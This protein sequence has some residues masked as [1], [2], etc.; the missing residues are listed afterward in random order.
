VKTHLITEENGSDINAILSNTHPAVS[1]TI[2]AKAGHNIIKETEK[3]G[4]LH[5]LR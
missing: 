2:E 5:L 3:T 1:E 4:H